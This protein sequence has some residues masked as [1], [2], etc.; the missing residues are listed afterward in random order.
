MFSGQE[1][2]PGKVTQ[3][4][5]KETSN[6]SGAKYSA[7]VD[8]KG[9]NIAIYCALPLEAD[10]MVSLFDTIWDKKRYPKTNV[11]Q[12]SYTFGAIGGQ[13]VVLVHLAGAGKNS[14]AIAASGC[15]FSF[16]SIKL[17]LVVGICGGVPFGA[18][19]RI[20]RVLG[21]VI[22]SE[23]LVQLDLGRRYPDRFAR[24]RTLQE[25][26]SRPC[27]QLRGF[28]SMLKSSRQLCSLIERT[29]LYLRDLHSQ[30]DALGKFIY[31]YPGPGRDVLFP[32]SYLHKHKTSALCTSWERTCGIEDGI[33]REAETLTC[34]DLD[35]ETQCD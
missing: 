20:E 31:E 25:N 29:N 27:V 30:T 12:N 32:P 6:T 24:K 15:C 26:L 33:C 7:P 34:E 22:I 3:G 4:A 9:F 1:K 10:A 35:C 11:D 28:L 17:S 21:D 19:G 18:G 13:N 5:Q 14:A 16:P 23:G 8:V 2:N